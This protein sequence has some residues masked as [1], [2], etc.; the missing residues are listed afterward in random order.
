MMTSRCLGKVVE[1]QRSVSATLNDQERA[2]QERAHQAE[3]EHEEVEQQ[4]A[5]V[6]AHAEQEMAGLRQHFEG[7]VLPELR[8]SYAME[9][10]E[11]VQVRVSTQVAPP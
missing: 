4:L 6:R 8:Q 11:V 5:A 7:T 1:A 3:M 9:V 10:R 2:R